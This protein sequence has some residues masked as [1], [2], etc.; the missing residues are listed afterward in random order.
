MAIESGMKMGKW[1]KYTELELETI[2]SRY[3]D[4]GAIGVAQLTGRSADSVKFL[5]YKM[6]IKVSS[7][8]RSDTATRVNKTWTRTEETKRRIGVGH[9]KYEPFVCRECGKH[10]SHHMEKCW[11]CYSKSR[12]EHVPTAAIARRMLYPV[13]IIP[14][15]VRDEFMCQDCGSPIDLVVHHLRK[16]SDITKI[17]VKRSGLTMDTPENRDMLAKLIVLEHT[18]DDGIT[19]CRKCHKETHGKKRGELLGTPYGDNQQPSQSNVKSIVDWKVQR[20]TLA[21][22]QSNK[23]DT[24][25]PLTDLLSVEMI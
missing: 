13:W 8:Y 11:S 23:S 10:C 7:Q 18:L 19:S 14:I 17:V 25:A 20:L 2:R 1:K 12:R 16:F 22:S 5:A 4:I 24:S 3:P 15:M 21:D 6:G 9:R